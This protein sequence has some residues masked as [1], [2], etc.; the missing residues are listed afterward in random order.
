MQINQQSLI[1]GVLSVSIFCMLTGCVDD[2]YDLKKIDATSQFKV[3]NLTI[4][5]R[6]SEIKLENVLGLE[7]N[8]LITTLPG[9]DGKE[10]YA[11]K[12][13]GDI[14]TSDFKIK[15]VSVDK[16]SIKPTKLT[17]EVPNVT[18]TPNV[19]VSIPTIKFNSSDA[20][21]YKF[22]MNNVDES[23][24][25]LTSIETKDPI[26][27][28][29]ELSLPSQLAGINNRYTFNNLVIQLPWGLVTEDSNYDIKT[30][31]LKIPS[32]STG[33]DGK[34]KLN[35]QA[36]GLELGDKGTISNGYLGIDGNVKIVSGDL[37]IKVKNIS[38]PN[39]IEITANYDV[40]GFE[41]SKISGKIDYK[42]EQ[43][44]IEPITLSDLPD[45]LDGSDTKIIIA[46]PNIT[47][48]ISNPVGEYGL[49]GTGKI[50]L[51]SE[52]KNGTSREEESDQFSISG[53]NSKLA[54]CTPVDGYTTV[55]FNGLRDILSNGD[56]GLPS[57]IYINISDIVFAGDV[58]DFP[59]ENIGNAKGDYAFTAPF[60]FGKG[61][62]VI[63]ESTE[64]GWINKDDKQITVETL[65]ITALCTTNIPV[66]VEL[67]ILPLD[68]N[69]N[70][71]PVK[72]NSSKFQVPAKCIDQPV[73][74]NIEGVNGSIKDLDGVIFR[75]IV[76]QPNDDTDPLTPTQFIKLTD[77]KAKVSGYFDLIDDKNK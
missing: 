75:A 58:T 39:S 17:V 33:S 20:Q 70:Q 46:N 50:K 40:S 8:D 22:E 55:G 49:N 30:G 64:D 41:I 5:I 1:K 24:K 34:A 12:Q 72:E 45:F 56:S 32:I 74:L 10:Y 67:Q 62:R 28:Q 66:S 15:S 16:L 76:S 9:E 27:I 37:D 63:Y 38:L 42:M 23:L 52:F 59:L 25:S 3:D 19:E 57:K 18:I 36:H 4:P 44:K 29:I 69:G 2:K 13:G 51:T 21:P 35:L 47:L 60:G 48:D 11:L 73:E 77:L 65:N 31:E 43:I 71:I 7:D 26:N 14:S 61:S 53:K 68:K 6:L 54:F